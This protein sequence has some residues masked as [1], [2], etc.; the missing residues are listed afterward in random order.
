MKS[1]AVLIIDDNPEFLNLMTHFMKENGCSVIT[2]KNAEEGMA[3][4]RAC[5]VEVIILDIM[6]PDGNGVDVLKSV[7]KI[8]P[9]VP[10]IMLTGKNDIETAT[11]CMRNGAVDYIT[12]PVD[13]E[14]LRT[15]VLSNITE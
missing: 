7:H 10:V 4:V 3:Q 5:K 11:E 12:K 8:I 1:S 6:L 14:Y 15:A 9:R 2:G 13:F